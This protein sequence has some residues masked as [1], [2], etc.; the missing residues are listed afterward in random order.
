MSDKHG[1]ACSF[2]G[3][4]ELDPSRMV[5]SPTS[6]ICDDCVQLCN[7]L[8]FGARAQASAMRVNNALTFENIPNPREIHQF[9]NE[10]VI[11]HEQAKK[12][13]SVAACNHYKR[14]KN[15]SEKVYGGV[16]S[17]VEIEK[18]NVLLLGPTG[19]G[20]TLL[21]KTLARF[22]NVPFAI[23]DATTLTEAGYVGDDVETLLLG[24]I[25]DAS[26]DILNAQRG[27]VYIDEIDKIARKSENASITRD[28]SGEGVQQALL[29]ILEGTTARVPLAGGRKH[30]QHK[31]VEIDTTNILFLCGGAFSGIEDVVKRRQQRAVSVVGFGGS[32]GGRS[33]VSGSMQV[34]PEDLVKFGLIPELVGRLPIVTSLSALSE[35]DLVDILVKPRNAIVK[36]YQRLME[37][38]GIDLSFTSEA[39][40]LIARRA[41]ERETGAR[42]LRSEIESLMLDVMYDTAMSENR[43]KK[44]TVTADM[45]ENSKVEMLDIDEAEGDLKCA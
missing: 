31:P 15:G 28:V 38:D 43:K 40:C 20:K 33:G 13:L 24:L 37:M 41:L 29:K 23:A 22:L 36:Q 39:L 12:I 7:E 19:S 18:S 9:L 35:S 25:R 26:S 3:K 45:V 34:E 17:D 14:L 2:C 5:V 27:I 30:P 44:L 16:N 21:A 42:G 1:S 11:G 8:L 32:L 6:N 4:K 10:H